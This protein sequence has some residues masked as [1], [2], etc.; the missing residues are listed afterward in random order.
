MR[1]RIGTVTLIVVIAGWVWY[2]SGNTFSTLG[3]RRI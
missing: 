3:A 2:R 1:W